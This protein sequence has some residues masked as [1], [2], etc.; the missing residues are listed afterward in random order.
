MGLC[1]N[2]LKNLNQCKPGQKK[3]E[4]IYWHA[5]FFVLIFIRLRSLLQQKVK[6]KK[7]RWRRKSK[8]NIKQCHCE[9]W[10]DICRNLKMS[11]FVIG[12]LAWWKRKRTKKKMNLGTLLVSH[13]SIG[14][15][16]DTSWLIPPFY[17]VIIYIILDHKTIIKHYIIWVWLCD[18][19]G[20]L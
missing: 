14:Q 15:I 16:N 1:K 10:F 17:S 8:T 7:K 20:Y 4:R 11:L 5:F 18:N 6:K 2:C 9:N 19:F 3:S 13:Y 12:R